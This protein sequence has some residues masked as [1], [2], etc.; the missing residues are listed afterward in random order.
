[1]G[2]VIECRTCHE[3]KSIS[4]IEHADPHET[5]ILC[6]LSEGA[7][8]ALGYAIYAPIERAFSFKI[9]DEDMRL[10]SR[11]TEEYILNQMGHGYKSLDFYKSLIR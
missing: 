3:K 2:G 5:H 4:H 1:M 10:F 9:S 7:K 8:I 11:A 6:I